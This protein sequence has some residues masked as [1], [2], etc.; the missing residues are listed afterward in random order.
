MKVSVEADTVDAEEVSA[1]ADSLS[2]LYISYYTL[3]RTTDLEAN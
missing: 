1:V 3:D 2:Y